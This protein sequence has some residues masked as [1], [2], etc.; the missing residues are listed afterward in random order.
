MRL[1]THPVDR[2]I[3]AL[4]HLHELDA[5]SALMRIVQTVVVIVQFHIV[6]GKPETF[7]HFGGFGER[8]L[9]KVRAAER[10]PIDRAHRADIFA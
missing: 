1:H 6:G 10:V 5:S 9:D 2:D 8:A 7:T 4:Q 3:C